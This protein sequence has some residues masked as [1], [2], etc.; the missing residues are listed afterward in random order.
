MAGAWLNVAAAFILR[1][2]LG[3][4]GNA[5]ARSLDRYVDLQH[6]DGVSY[7]PRRRGDDRVARRRAATAAVLAGAAAAARQRT[8]GLPP[9]LE[10]R[11]RDETLAGLEAALGDEYAIAYAEGAELELET[12]VENARALAIARGRS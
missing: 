4:A 3:G 6:F 12:A 9:P 8:G 10:Q 2:D 1:G 5:L 11:L 7:L